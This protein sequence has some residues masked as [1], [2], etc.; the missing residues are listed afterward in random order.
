[1]RAPPRRFSQ[2]TT[3]FFACPCQGIPRAPFLRLTESLPFP[4]YA[5]IEVPFSL[6]F[7]CFPCHSLLPPGPILSNEQRCREGRRR[8]RTCDGRHS[9]A[10]CGQHQAPEDRP[11]RLL[12]APERR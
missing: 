12:T 9:S 7:S 3:P 1:M 2:L 10:F 5:H 6:P 4:L 11:T 8:R